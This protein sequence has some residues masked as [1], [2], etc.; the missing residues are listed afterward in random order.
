[1]AHLILELVLPLLLLVSQLS[2]LRLSI[3]RL[4]EFCEVESDSNQVLITDIEIGELYVEVNNGF[5]STG[6]R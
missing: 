1:M 6:E 2:R 3:E 4:I 5:V